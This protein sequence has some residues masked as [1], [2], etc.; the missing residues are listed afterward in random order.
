MNLTLREFSGI[1]KTDHVGEKLIKLIKEQLRVNE[2]E[3]QAL[4]E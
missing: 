3:N 2:I 4:M 1:F